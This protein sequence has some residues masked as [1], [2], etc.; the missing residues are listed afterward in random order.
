[1]SDEKISNSGQVRLTLPKRREV[2]TRAEDLVTSTPLLAGSS[3][4]LVITPVVP[5]VQL[6]AWAEQQKDQLEAQLVLHG[7][8]LFRGFEIGSTSTFEDVIRAI[9]GELL[10]YEDRSSPR[11]QVSGNVYTSTDHPPDQDIFLHNEKS[12]SVSWPAKIFFYCV[13]P[14]QSG[15]DTPIANCRTIFQRLSPRI[16]D[17]FMRKGIRYVRNFGDGFGLSWQTAFQTEDRREVEQLCSNAQMEWQWKDSNRLSIRYVRRAALAHPR[18]GEMTWFNHGTFFHITT[19]PKATQSLLLAELGEENLPYNTYY[20]DGTVIEPEVLDEL[21]ACYQQETIRFSWEKG[22]ILMLDNMLTAHARTAY[23]GPRKIL[24]GM[25]EPLTWDE[26][27][28][29]QAQHEL[30]SRTTEVGEA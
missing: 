28:F 29:A 26:I 10:T 24:V 11:S 12:H 9:S 21:R 17:G 5:G 7:A 16:R 8:I 4:P 13:Q 2:S 23:V 20:G 18:T 15:G 1:M 22:D 3:L 6:A 27:D 25:A 19:L 30:L 14:A